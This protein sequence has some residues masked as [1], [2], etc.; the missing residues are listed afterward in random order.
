MYCWDYNGYGQLGDGTSTTRSLAE[1][2]SGMSSGVTAISLGSHHSCAA[3]SVEAMYCWGW[4]DDGQL[5]DGTTLTKN[6]AVAVSGMS[7][8]VMAISTGYV[9]TCG[10]T[11]R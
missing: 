6:T 5:G 1:I 7:S 3:T 10:L 2:V 9:H 11:S 8:G 4:N